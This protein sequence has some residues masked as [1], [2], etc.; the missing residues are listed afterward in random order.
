MSYNYCYLAFRV[1]K[2]CQVGCR[3]ARLS[4]GRGLCWHNL[5]GLCFEH[6]RHILLMLM[7]TYNYNNNR[8]VLENRTVESVY[9]INIIM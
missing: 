1:V 2:Y 4:Q 6:N 3:Q 8:Q 9:S 5:E 7:G